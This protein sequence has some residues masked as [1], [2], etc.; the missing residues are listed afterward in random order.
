[1]HVS[2]KNYFAKLKDNQSKKEAFINKIMRISCDFDDADYYKAA[3]T[4]REEIYSS[5][6]VWLSRSMIANC[7]LSIM[8]ILTFFIVLK[9]IGAHVV[10]PIVIEK[11]RATGSYTVI[12]RVNIENIAADWSMTRFNIMQYVEAR[13]QYHFDNVN[14]PYHDTIYKSSKDVADEV[15]REVNPENK[16]APYNTYGDK[17]YVTAK[18][19]NIQ[20]L[21][22]NNTALVEFT[23]TL[24]E[25][26]SDRSKDFQYRAVVKWQY[27]KDGM[28]LKEYYRNP[29][30]FRVTYY[31]SSIVTKAKG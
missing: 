4:W 19:N 5:Q 11:D 22:E 12:D 2:I 23:K 24:H 31:K 25:K 29:F 28:D 3:K 1:M 14:V 13:E 7:I 15:W 18:V 8:L 10:E 20:K 27:S 16:K 9:Q 21:G 17:K 6:K 26:G 30:N